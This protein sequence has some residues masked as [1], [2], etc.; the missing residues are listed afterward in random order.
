MNKGKQKMLRM[1]WK[2]GEIQFVRS[3][4]EEYTVFRLAESPMHFDACIAL[5]VVLC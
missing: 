1:N 4:A 2:G 5:R 3:L